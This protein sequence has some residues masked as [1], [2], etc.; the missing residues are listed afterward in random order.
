MREPNWV[1]FV[2]ILVMVGI[3]ATFLGG[4]RRWVAPRTDQAIPRKQEEVIESNQL[5]Q[6]IKYIEDFAYPNASEEGVLR[7]RMVPSNV[8]PDALVGGPGPTIQ[9]TNAS[10]EAIEI[11]YGY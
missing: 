6:T 5:G 3:A 8:R 4:S 9:L 7:L 10:P 11:P 1:N 2:A